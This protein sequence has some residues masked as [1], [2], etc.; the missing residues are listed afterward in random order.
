MNKVFLSI[1]YLLLFLSCKKT[2]TDRSNDEIKFDDSIW[3]RISV[4]NAGEIHAV[5]G[6]LD[7]TLLVTT[8]TKAYFTVDRGLTWKES[9]NF[10]GPVPG[11][12]TIKD[13]IYAL[14]ATSTDETSKKSYAGISSYYTLNRGLTWSLSS[15]SNRYRSMQTG[16]AMTSNK[17]AFRLNYHSGSDI[18]GRGSSYVL[19]TTI[20]KADNNGNDISFSHPIDKQPLNLYIDSKDRL[21]V[22]CSGGEITKLGTI[23]GPSVFDTAYIYVTKG[24]VQQ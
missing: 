9:K 19:R 1:V 16:M 20:S 10:N 23:I 7:D 17:Y 12:L 18:N 22:A 3:N 13:T 15:Y 8:M 4:P 6:N 14:L 2:E 24:P 5:A 21:Y 11:L